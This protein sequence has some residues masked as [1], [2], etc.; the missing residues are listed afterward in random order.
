MVTVQIPRMVV[1]MLLRLSDNQENLESLTLLI[2]NPDDLHD[3][4]TLAD[5]YKKARQGGQR[6][7]SMIYFVGAMSAFIATISL[8]GGKA[9]AFF[10][11]VHK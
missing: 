7:L 11:W 10:G 6:M 9:L 2:R 3:L 5:D 4:F 1:D 8:W